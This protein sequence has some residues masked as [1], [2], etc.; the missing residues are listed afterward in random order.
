MGRVLTVPL[1][2]LLCPLPAALGKSSRGEVG[3]WAA[4]PGP[5]AAVP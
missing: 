4:G 2:Y 3:H 5:M 1:P